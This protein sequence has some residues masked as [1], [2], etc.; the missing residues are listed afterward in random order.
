MFFASSPSFST[1]NDGIK[2]FSGIS[3]SEKYAR[4]MFSFCC[5]LR[6]S[7]GRKVTAILAEKRVDGELVFDEKVIMSEFASVLKT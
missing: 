3:S 1:Q 5:R 4:I 2:S 7:V 6:C